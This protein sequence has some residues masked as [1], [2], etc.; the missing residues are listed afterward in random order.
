MDKRRNRLNGCVFYVDLAGSVRLERE[1][2]WSWLRRAASASST[3][4]RYPLRTGRPQ[5]VRVQ[6]RDLQVRDY[7]QG[8]GER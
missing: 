3:F 1:V 2:E 5:P 8:L 6:T 7:M 4:E